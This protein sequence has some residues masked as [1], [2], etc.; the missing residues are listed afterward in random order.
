MKTSESTFLIINEKR[1]GV[2]LLTMIFLYK[3]TEWGS[4]SHQFILPLR[5]EIISVLGFPSGSAVKNPP[6]NAG[7]MGLITGSR[8][9]PGERNG[10]PFKYSCLGNPMNRG[11]WQTLV[12]GAAKE[13]GMT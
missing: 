5:A 8:R 10:N 4:R 11:A 2:S 3:I 9:F 12:Y 7:D 13:L 1:M 6:A